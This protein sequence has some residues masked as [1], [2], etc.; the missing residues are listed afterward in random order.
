LPEDQELRRLLWYVLGGARGGENRARIIR[1]LRERPRNM[2]Q[3]SESLGLD[4]RT[5]MHHVD[6]LK[7]NSL[8]VTEG[9]RYGM[10]CFLSPRL[11]ASYGIFEEI[12]VSLRLRTE[13]E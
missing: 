5:I 11:E 12:V 3:L 6:V 10:M 7:T 4:Y 8:I 13:D 1:R 2:N 9:E